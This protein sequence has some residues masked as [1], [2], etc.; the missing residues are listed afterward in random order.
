MLYLREI[1]DLAPTVQPN[2]DFTPIFP[3]LR[4]YP[5]F[6]RMKLP[7]APLSTSLADEH[8][9][10]IKKEKR[11]KIM[12]MD[13]STPPTLST[14]HTARSAVSLVLFLARFLSSLTHETL[15]HAVAWI[16]EGGVVTWTPRTPTAGQ[17]AWEGPGDPSLAASQVQEA[18]SPAASM[19]I[20]TSTNPLMDGA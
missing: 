1:G 17:A 16:E 4:F 15:G 5:S 6:S 14:R 9:K 7:S 11:L 20:R 12:Q 13:Q 19:Q 8:S 3:T 18:P 2:G 10:N